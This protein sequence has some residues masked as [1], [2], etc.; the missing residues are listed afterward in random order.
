MNELVDL[1]FLFGTLVI[2]AIVTQFFI[3]KTKKKADDEKRDS[4]LKYQEEND[5][6]HPLQ[7]FVYPKMK[8]RKRKTPKD[9]PEE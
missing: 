8:R 4:F 1:I 7:P 6:N 9:P 2:G 5:R 3:N